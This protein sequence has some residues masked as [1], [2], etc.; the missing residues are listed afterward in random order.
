MEEIKGKSEK[1]R[2][3]MRGSSKYFS[4]FFFSVY[5]FLKLRGHKYFHISEQG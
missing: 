2:K 4:Y 1:E 5:N 3:R